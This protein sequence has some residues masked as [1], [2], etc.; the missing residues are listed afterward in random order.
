MSQNDRINMNEY[1][2]S[3][4]SSSEAIRKAADTSVLVNVALLPDTAP[5]VSRF[6]S[7][8]RTVAIVVLTVFIPDQV[9]WAFGYN[10]AVIWGNRIPAVRMIE[11]GLTLPDAAY[12]AS[13][14]VEYLLKQIINKPNARL[15]IK[16]PPTPSFKK[17]GGGDVGLPPFAQ[18]GAG[19]GLL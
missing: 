14:S 3:G 6:H 13:Q 12:Q 11:P 18:E 15:Q 2:E 4:E 1:P 16:L 5:V 10:P 9:S 8:I 7:W 19:G 17:K